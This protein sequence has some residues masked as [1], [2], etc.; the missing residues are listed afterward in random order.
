MKTN[1][2]IENEIDKIRLE[3]YNKTKHMTNQELTEYY[4]K[5]GEESAKKYGFKIVE[6][7]T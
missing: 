5:S 6:S 1:S 7:A 2:R 3:I 4:R